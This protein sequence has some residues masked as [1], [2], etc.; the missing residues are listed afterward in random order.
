MINGTEISLKVDKISNVCWKRQLCQED[1]I[2][3]TLY[4]VYFSGK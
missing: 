4:F 3:E 1:I 2:K